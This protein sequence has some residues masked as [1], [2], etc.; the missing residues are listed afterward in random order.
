V[1]V[2]QSRIR[3]EEEEQ[4]LKNEERDRKGR[5]KAMSKRITPFLNDQRDQ[6][7]AS[8][9]EQ[10]L[11]RKR[12]AFDQEQD[13]KNRLVEMQ[14]R[15]DNAP[16]LLQKDAKA[17]AQNQIAHVVENTLDELNVNLGMY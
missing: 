7:L 2:E 12:N 4:R 8:I 16:L 14:E 13:Y 6:L 11:D 3:F 10:V 9:Q 1:V 17:N 15:V 5:V